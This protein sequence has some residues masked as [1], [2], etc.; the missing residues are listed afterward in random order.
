[1]GIK[2]IAFLLTIV[3]T[4]IFV[5]AANAEIEPR[6]DGKW[7][8]DIITDDAVFSSI[9]GN[10]MYGDRLM[11]KLS[12]QDCDV[13]NV[14]TTIYSHKSI[15][16]VS[17]LTGEKIIVKLGQHEIDAVVRH[18]SK[19]LI[20]SRA[21][22]DF[23]FAHIIYLVQRYLARYLRVIFLTVTVLDHPKKVLLI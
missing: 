21:I 12:V 16:A 7:G 9:N 1:M 11:L 8:V 14:L 19:F 18:T 13:V 5:Y 3:N 22:I 20:G 10:V 15:D 17:K 6:E 23:G 4:F 2:A